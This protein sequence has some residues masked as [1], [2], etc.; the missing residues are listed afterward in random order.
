MLFPTFLEKKKILGGG[1][2][3]KRNH[4]DML[5]SLF[6]I[7]GMLFDFEFVKKIVFSFNVFLTFYPIFLW[8]FERLKNSPS[9]TVCSTFRFRTVTPLHLLVMGSDFSK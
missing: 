2:G 4:G 3:G 8:I 7:D 1:G 9:L 6:Y 5:Y